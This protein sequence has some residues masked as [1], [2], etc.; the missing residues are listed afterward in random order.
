MTVH[1]ILY[2]QDQARSTAFYSKV[3][4]CSPTL[5]VAGMTEFNLSD[6]SILGLMPESGIK[7]LLG[8]KLPN[9]ADARGIPRAE[10]YLVVADPQGYHQRAIEAGATEVSGL[11]DRDWGHRVA[12]CLDLDGHV[13]AF[14]EPTSSDSK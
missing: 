3:L 14:A 12:Y 5:D 7:S 10:L 2:V 9:P 4:D 8:E 6:N 11:A 1:F 13:I